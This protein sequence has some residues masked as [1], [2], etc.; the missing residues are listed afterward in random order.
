MEFT[1]LRRDNSLSL[2]MFLKTWLL[3]IVTETCSIIDRSNKESL[4]L[5]ATCLVILLTIFYP[6][7][8]PADNASLA[9]EALSVIR[10]LPC[11]W[12][13]RHYLVKDIYDNFKQSGAFYHSEF[14]MYRMK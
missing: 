1:S 11:M 10:V 4:C 2:N 3:V 8:V 9:R 12:D 7:N 13:T 14:F 5:T 6:S